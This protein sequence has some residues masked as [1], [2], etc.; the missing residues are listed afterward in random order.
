MLFKLSTSLAGL[1]DIRTVNLIP[2]HYDE[3]TITHLPEVFLN[4]VIFVPLGVYLKI[5]TNKKL[6]INALLVLFTSLFFEVLQFIFAIGGSDITD[7]ITNTVG[8]ICGI[9][10]CIFLKKLAPEKFISVFNVCGIIIEGAGLTL[11]TVLTVA[12]S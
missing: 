4:V 9:F 11:L 6:L 1:P 10:L 5:C 2:F 3:E 7:I 12:N 8:G